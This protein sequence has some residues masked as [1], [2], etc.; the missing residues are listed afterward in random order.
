MGC[1]GQRFQKNL[2][3]L[4]WACLRCA[5][6]PKSGR[7]CAVPFS[8]TVYFFTEAV[9]LAASNEQKQAI[10][11]KVAEGDVI[12]AW[13]FSEGP[14][15]PDASNL[16]TSFDGSVV[17]GVKIPVTDGDIATHAIV[18]AKE[19]SGA[20]LVLVDLSADGVTR[21]TVKTLDPTRSHAQIE[22]NNAGRASRCSRCGRGA[23]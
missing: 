7:A 14:G 18:F 9:K 23:R 21:K 19:G 22:F 6:W 17:N 10:L 16:K 11:P 13:A 15:A 4:A 2:V 1:L 20:S 3:V 5:F 12:G 8:S